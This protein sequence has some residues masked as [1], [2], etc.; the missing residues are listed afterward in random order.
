MSASLTHNLSR[1][2]HTATTGS[3]KAP[4]RRLLNGTYECPQHLLEPMSALAEQASS[5]LHR[6]HRHLRHSASGRS[7]RRASL[8]RTSPRGATAATAATCV[9]PD[10]PPDG[11][12]RSL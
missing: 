3:L 2:V 12:S 7:F 4:S 10:R 11:V 9:R 8:S 1:A 5:P 6:G